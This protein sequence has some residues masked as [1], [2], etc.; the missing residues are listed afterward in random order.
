MIATGEFAMIVDTGGRDDRLPMSA[1]GFGSLI[2]RVQR[3]GL[4]DRAPGRFDQRPAG[5]RRSAL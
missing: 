4:Q 1:A 2:E 5:G 3:S